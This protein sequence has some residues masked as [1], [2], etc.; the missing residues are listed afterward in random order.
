MTTAIR[1]QLLAQLGESIQGRTADEWLRDLRALLEADPGPSV[2]REELIKIAHMVGVYRSDEPWALSAVTEAVVALTAT[3]PGPDTEPADPYL[4]DIMSPWAVLSPEQQRVAGQ[5]A[6]N[7]MNDLSTVMPPDLPSTCRC[8]EC[9]AYRG[10]EELH[11]V[12]VATLRARVAALAGAAE[13]ATAQEVAQWDEVC[14]SVRNPEPDTED[15]PKCSLPALVS[16]GAYAT[17]RACGHEV[18]LASYPEPTCAPADGVCEA[19]GGEVT[20]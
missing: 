8:S 18:E 10:A 15:C 11:A 13:E 19:P 16:I 17:C 14:R 12:E 4:R 2:E 7:G 9:E 3:D 6:M 5:A 1:K 20:A